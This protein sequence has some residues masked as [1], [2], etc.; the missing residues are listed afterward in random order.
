VSKKT[1]IKT[2]REGNNMTPEEI[3]SNYNVGALDEYD[4][5]NLLI[6]E[7][8]FDGEDAKYYLADYD[9]D[10][11][12][13]PAPLAESKSPIGKHRPYEALRRAAG[14]NA[15]VRDPDDP[16]FGVRSNGERVRLP[17]M[18]EPRIKSSDM[19]GLSFS[20]SEPGEL[21]FLG[22]RFF[23]GILGSR[24][25]PKPFAA[26]GGETVPFSPND[27][28]ST[29]RAF[30]SIRRGRAEKIVKMGESKS[31]EIPRLRELS[32]PGVYQLMFRGENGGIQD[33]F[34]FSGSDDEKR[35]RALT[36]VSKRPGSFIKCIQEND[37][38]HRDRLSEGGHRVQL[39]G[40]VRDQFIHHILLIKDP[41]KRR[42]EMAKIQK[43]VYDANVKA[44]LKANPD[45]TKAEA[46][47]D[48]NTKQKDAISPPLSGSL[49][50]ANDGRNER[51]IIRRI[52]ESF[53]LDDDVAEFYVLS[54]LGCDD[55]QSFMTD[56]VSED[57]DEDSDL[58]GAVAIPYAE[59]KDLYRHIK[60]MAGGLREGRVKEMLAERIEDARLELENVLGHALDDEEYYDTVEP[61]LWE[62]YSHSIDA[63]ELVDCVMAADG[64]DLG[65]EGDDAVT[66]MRQLHSALPSRD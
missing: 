31:T 10:E 8:G 59:A 23:E 20:D 28:E 55:E 53:G 25:G 5:I 46:E 40:D 1:K 63:E 44:Y 9:M 60:R 30:N 7:C 36:A 18:D 22:E 52:G 34:E 27:D 65:D 37:V 6:E 45:A 66:I 47:A 62:Y 19:G 48:E 13:D 3:Y 16:E 39:P 51:E 50:E 56:I 58:C 42:D 11:L 17:V 26:V 14:K 61:K 24:G 43:E 21:D 15:I 41:Q 12:D 64:F 2:L 35:N 33:G 57:E 32:V 38:N 29:L 4:A 54:A 49:K